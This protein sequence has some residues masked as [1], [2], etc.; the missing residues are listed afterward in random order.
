MGLIGADGHREPLELGHNRLGLRSFANYRIA[1]RHADLARASH[2]SEY[3]PT[4]NA[5]LDRHHTPQDQ[6]FT[7]GLAEG[8]LVAQIGRGRLAGLCGDFQRGCPGAN[9]DSRALDVR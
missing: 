8:E 7:G 4:L 3:D 1:Q 2:R 9:V 6:A 5:Y